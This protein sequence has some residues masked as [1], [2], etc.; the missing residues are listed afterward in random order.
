VKLPSG[1]YLVPPGQVGAALDEV[2]PG[3]RRFVRVNG[4]WKIKSFGFDDETAG[5]AVPQFAAGDIVDLHLEWDQ[6]LNAGQGAE[7]LVMAIAQDATTPL[8]FSPTAALFAMGQTS[9]AIAAKPLVPAPGRDAAFQTMSGIPA[10]DVFTIEKATLFTGF[11]GTEGQYEIEGDNGMTLTQKRILRVPYWYS[12]YVPVFDKAVV[13]KDQQGMD[14]GFGMQF[15]R[16]FGFAPDGKVAVYDF[17]RDY[18]MSQPRR[19]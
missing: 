8:T 14:V 5:P 18:L 13:R 6:A 4:A 3:H 11:T 12:T 17:G 1:F 16:R 9:A 15:N 19:T 7:I 2:K 10:V